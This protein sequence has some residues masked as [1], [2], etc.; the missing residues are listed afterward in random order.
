MR[1]FNLDEA[2]AGAPICTRLGEPAEILKVGVK[3][4]PNNGRSFVALVHSK[5]F[6]FDCSYT[7]YEDGSYSFREQSDEDLFM[8][9]ATPCFFIESKVKCM[10]EKIQYM[11][12]YAES[13]EEAKDKARNFLISGEQ[14]PNVV[15]GENHLEEVP[16]SKS[17]IYLEG[18]KEGEKDV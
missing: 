17:I 8:Q 15:V 9:E 18:K 13:L 2:L 4:F 16:G 3:N 6:S 7:Y 5:K 1:P 11:T 14:N 10:V 12:I